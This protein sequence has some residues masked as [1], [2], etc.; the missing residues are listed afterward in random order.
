MRKIG[1]R[2]FESIIFMLPASVVLNFQFWSF[3]SWLIICFLAV[4]IFSSGIEDLSFCTFSSKSY[5]CFIVFIG[6]RPSFSFSQCRFSI[7]LS[8]LSGRSGKVHLQYF[9]KCPNPLL[10]AFSISSFPNIEIFAQKYGFAVLTY[11]ISPLHIVG[12]LLNCCIGSQTKRE[13]ELQT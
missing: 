5:K 11:N 4:K 2:I 6:S 10:L 8:F 12:L 7:L 9:C 3:Q 1:G 13:N